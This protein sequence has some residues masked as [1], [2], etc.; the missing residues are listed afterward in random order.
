MVDRTGNRSN[1]YQFLLLESPYSPD[2]LT[3]FSDSQGMTGYVNSLANGEELLD[4]QEQLLVEFWRIVEESLTDRQKQ[5]LKLSAK[6]GLTQVEVAKKLGVNQSSVTKSIWG[7]T[8]YRNGKKVYGGAS[9][10]IR[11]LAESDEKIQAILKRIAEI[12]S[13][14]NM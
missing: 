5:V 1:K 8:D 3:E 6:E 12:K 9:K 7:N 2:M 11:K 4:L 13:E 10:K 14:D